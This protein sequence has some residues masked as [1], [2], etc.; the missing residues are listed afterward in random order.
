MIHRITTR[1]LTE[2]IHNGTSDYVVSDVTTHVTHYTLD[3]LSLEARRHTLDNVA[4]REYEMLDTDDLFPVIREAWAFALAD[5]GGGEGSRPD[6]EEMVAGFDIVTRDE[7]DVIGT[8]T[9]ENAPKLPWVGDT[10]SVTMDNDY[11]MIV[12]NAFGDE[13]ADYAYSEE[14]LQGVRNAMQSAIKAGRDHLDYVQTHENAEDIIANSDMMFTQDGD[15][16]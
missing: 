1:V 3:E 5:D 15:I 10:G 2:N 9:P 13:V 16:T 11:G 6:L 7:L 4:E 14:V 12:R 8:L